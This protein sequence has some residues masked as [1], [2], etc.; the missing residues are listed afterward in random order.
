MPESIVPEKFGTV[1]ERRE[2]LGRIAAEAEEKRLV[3]IDRERREALERQAEQRKRASL[4]AQIEAQWKEQKEAAERNKSE[5]IREWFSRVHSERPLAQEVVLESGETRLVRKGHG[6][7]GVVRFKQ[8]MLDGE[9][10]M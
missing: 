10:E 2:R 8:F 1:V 5:M 4:Y 9:I 3:E 7:A 6:I